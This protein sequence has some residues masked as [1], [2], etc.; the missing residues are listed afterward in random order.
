MD[1]LNT[2]NVSWRLGLVLLVSNL[3]SGFIVAMGFIL[4]TR[5]IIKDYN[6]NID[7][8]K[9]MGSI[10]VSLALI[11]TVS[12]ITS[13]ILSKNIGKP[14][15]CVTRILNYMSK[16]DLTKDF[17]DKD[18]LNRKDELGEMSRSLITLKDSLIYIGRGIKE[19]SIDILK[20]SVTMEKSL[21]ETEGSISGIS[22]TMDEL[23]KGAIEL[24]ESTQ[25]GSEKLESLSDKILLLVNETSVLKGFS[26]EEKKNISNAL[27]ALNILEERFAENKNN[28][29]NTFTIVSDLSKKS[30]SIG[31]I[32]NVI[33]EIAIRTNL[34][35][36]NATIEAAKA[37]ENGKG[38][39]VIAEEIRNLSE[40]TKESTKV[41]GDILKEL[42]LGIRDSK[43]NMDKCIV[44][45]QESYKALKK[46]RGY[47][48]IMDETYNKTIEKLNILVKN[49]ERMNE[50]REVVMYSIQEI[51]SVS[52][53]TAAGTEEVSALIQKQISSM[54]KVNEFGI[55]LKTISKKLNDYTKKIIVK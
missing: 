15:Q 13:L 43:E 46:E 42:K 1:K 27:E 22:I 52:E 16:F 9:G 26:L 5:S 29:E 6:S 39:S 32:I 50:D 10:I 14:V 44:A 38:F 2:K 25:N 49:M 19:S 3:L 35:S 20:G 36:L 37:K 48:D 45:N 47:F 4:N 23:S 30:E 18:V 31:D 17:I 28:I 41:I 7:I 8:T 21:K 40:K 12:L 54:E 55:N 53:E 51:A 33:E 24:A 11:L 34:L